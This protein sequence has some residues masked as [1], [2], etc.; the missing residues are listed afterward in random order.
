M[1]RRLKLHNEF[2]DILGTK[3]E[4]DTR[5]YFQTPS[6]NNMTYPCIKYNYADPSIRRA[7][8]KVY[9]YTEKYEVI[10]IDYDPESPIPR[11]ILER[12]MM[13]RIDRRYRADNLNHTVL[14]LYY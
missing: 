11:Q 5:V 1:E 3:D 7:N 14:T 6:S 4:K 13:C 10:V 9:N 2:I 12:I 8:D